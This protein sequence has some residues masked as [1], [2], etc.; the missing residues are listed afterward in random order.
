MVVII[1]KSTIHILLQNAVDGLSL[2]WQS[3]LLWQIKQ[4]S[5]IQTY[6]N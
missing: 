1:G 2:A 6:I 3:L 5:V 4:N